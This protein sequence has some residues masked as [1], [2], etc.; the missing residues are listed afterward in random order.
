MKLLYQT[1]SPYA[2]KVLVAIHEIG[3]A[4]SVEVIH[5]ETSPTR[6]NEDVYA[7]NPLGKVPVLINDDGLVL[8][9]S[10]VIADYLSTLPGG[11]V[12]IPA[13]GKA[14]WDTLRLQAAAQ[15]IAD[16]G[17]VVRWETERRPEPVR[18][19]TMRDAQLQK[20]IAACD[21]A[22]KEA[23]LE[24]LPLIGEV[25]LATTLNWVE[26]RNIYPFTE[27][28][29]RLAAW[30]AEFCLRQSMQATSFSGETHD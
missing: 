8:F 12:L 13:T 6:R 5:H 16:S 3:L 22:E 18:W 23:A 1:H 29:P 11:N 7:L 9:D 14:R 10:V 27:G 25:A 19:A 17:I 24:G 28:R 4:D 15:G 26:F 21:F 20:I 30:Y 2:R